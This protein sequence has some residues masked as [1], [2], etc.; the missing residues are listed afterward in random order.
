MKK[1]LFIGFWICI[2]AFVLAFHFGPGLMFWQRDL[3]SDHI[4]D[5]RAAAADSDWEAVYTS[6]N[7]AELALPDA[8]AKLKE[9]LRFAAAAARIKSGKIL[10]GIE[11]LQTMLDESELE[12]NADRYT[13]DLSDRIRNELA[14]GAYHAGVL[15]RKEGATEDE[16]KPEVERARQHFRLLAEKASDKSDVEKTETFKKNLEATIRL[17]H[18]SVKDVQ[19]LP[20]PKSCPKCN[21][22]LSQKKRKQRI[23]KSKE[24]KGEGESDAR[25]KMKKE[26]D[27]SG[28]SPRKGS[29]S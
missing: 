27:A 1:R 28:H 16:W 11:D 6:L 25:E 5:A 18:M 26:K 29:G 3:A 23:S 21:G 20:L 8:D 19:A 10:E 12:D 14:T 9:E 17:E 2:P 22:S 24:G 13:E 7:S 4:A 15:M